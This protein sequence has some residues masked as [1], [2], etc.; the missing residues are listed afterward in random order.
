MGFIAEAA[1]TARSTLAWL[2]PA[3]L[4]TTSMRWSGRIQNVMVRRLIA[5][6]DYHE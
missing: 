4:T 5:A 6:A 2:I 3:L 1:E